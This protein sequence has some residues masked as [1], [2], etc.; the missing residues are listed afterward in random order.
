LIINGVSYDVTLSTNSYDAL[1]TGAAPP[2]TFAANPANAFLAENP[3]SDALIAL[4]VT[5]LGGIPCAALH[6]SIIR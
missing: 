2:P 5:G 1:F 6:R 4:G 3:L